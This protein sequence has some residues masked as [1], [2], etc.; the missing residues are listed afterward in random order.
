[1]VWDLSSLA[2]GH[3]V[4]TILGFVG[5]A[6]LA[7]TL[8]TESYGLVEY[9]V[10]LAGLGAIAIEGGMGSLGTLAVAR[11][12]TRAPELA[13][14]IPVARFLVALLVVP[15]VGL[16][17][18]TAGVGSNLAS[19]TWLFALSLFAIPFKQD[20]LLQGLERMSYVA[21]AQ[22]LKSAAFAAGVLVAIRGPGD[23]V[24]V[25]VVEIV[26][27]FVVAAYF[28]AVQRA[29][30]IPVTLDARPLRVWPLIRSGAAVSISN[31]VWPFIVYAPIFL[32]TNLA[33]STQAAWL[34]G[35]QRIVVA[36]VGF[37]AVYFFSLYPAMAHSLSE[38]RA[39]CQRLMESSFRVVAWAS[40]GVAAGITLFA[41][42]IIT[43]AFGE[44]F[45]PAARAL[46]VYVW[47][48]PV[49]LL[50]WHARWM[51]L[52]AERQ[53]A[54]LLAETGCAATLVLSGLV[55]VPEYG[56]TGGACSALLATTVG[57]GLAHVCAERFVGPVP[58]ARRALLPTAAAAIC[59]G[60]A[61][62]S[63]GHPAVS[64]AI[65]MITCGACM[66]FGSRELV[67]DVVWLA[68][69]KRLDERG[70][71]PDGDHGSRPGG[72]T[73]AGRVFGDN[74]LC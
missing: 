46:S 49:R 16:S 1:M 2:T 38:D 55:L 67:A 73:R 35:V 28:A 26:A 31:V 66:R 59:V 61:W 57:W 47:I 8:S 23:L 44:S 3:V 64:L 6:Y 33:G 51:L 48:L 56:A 4:S 62:L 41:G 17:G 63:G 60:A 27:A 58:R 25:G 45:L 10:G 71:T 54:L 74:D 18:Y 40:I 11:D 68:N 30:S 50:S 39:R 53:G 37:S 29:L 5:F 43:L 7:R 9:T 69:V 21:P 12:A 15:L 20:W 72:S 32:V 13:L 42:P 65:V 24:S 36:L 22:A 52:A 70:H 34:G 14:R 19:L